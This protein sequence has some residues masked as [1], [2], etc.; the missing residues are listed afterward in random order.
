MRERR[1]EGS[2]SVSQSTNTESRSVPS[3]VLGSGQS[4]LTS[5]LGSLGAQGVP[6]GEHRSH[7]QARAEGPPGAGVGGWWGAARP[8]AEV[9]SPWAES[10][11][12]PLPTSH[13]LAWFV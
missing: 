11:S 12:G 10:D 5:S 8:G 1:G 3:T 13:R 4:V 6:I 9:W 2:E 7:L